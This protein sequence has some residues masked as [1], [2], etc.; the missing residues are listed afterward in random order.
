M[1]GGA[2]CHTTAEIRAF[3]NTQFQSCVISCKAKVKWLPYSPNLPWFFWSYAM[4]HLRKQKLLIINELKKNLQS[5]GTHESRAYD[6]RPSGQYPQK[7]QCPQTNGRRPFWVVFV[8][9][10]KTVLNSLSG[11]SFIFFLGTILFEICPHIRCQSRK[12]IL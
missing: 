4:I 7:K 11:A 1:Q 6:P 3:F 10:K 9:P 5:H 2:T 8:I 12:I